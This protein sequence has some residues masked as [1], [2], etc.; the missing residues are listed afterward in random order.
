MQS[1]LS[2]AAKVVCARQWLSAS[3]IIVSPMWVKLAAIA[4]VVLMTVALAGLLMTELRVPRPE[5]LVISALIV[6][7]FFVV[8]SLS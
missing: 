2:P 6:F 8:P 1:R 4:V 5:A 3:D 7:F